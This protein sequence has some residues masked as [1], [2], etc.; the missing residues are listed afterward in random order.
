MATQYCNK[1][2]LWQHTQIQN[3]NINMHIINYN[4]YLINYLHKK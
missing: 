2:L 1:Y 3:I 4:E